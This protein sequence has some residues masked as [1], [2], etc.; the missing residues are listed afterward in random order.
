M[1]RGHCL[2]AYRQGIFP[3][4]GEGD[5]LLWW[6][7]NPR[8]SILP[9]TLHIST[10]SAKLLKRGRFV[11]TLDQDFR[12]VIAS[13]AYIQRPGQDGT[14]ILPEMIQAYE[15]LHELGFAHS[16]EAWKDGR[17]VG[18]LYGV[19]L[20]GAFFGES[21]FSVVSGASRAG[22]LS[23]AAML[24]ERGFLLIDSQVH[25]D[26]VAGMG[27]VDIPRKSYL[28]RLSKAL[29]LPDSRGAWNQLFPLFP[30][31]D[32][33]ASLRRSGESRTMPARP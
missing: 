18:G 1:S 15:K 31:S 19:S 23:L 7:P 20:G 27:G 6:S 4:Y 22:F 12:Q 16:V 2:S 25:T 24:F 11:L 28:D 29:E 30:A 32:R 26:Y 33:L 10:S 3:W 8:F 17:L 5:P 14:W 21:M 9:E 13:C